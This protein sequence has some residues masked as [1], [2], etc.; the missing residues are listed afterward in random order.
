VQKENDSFM[1]MCSVLNVLTGIIIKYVGLKNLTSMKIAKKIE[2]MVFSFKLIMLG[3][4]M[5]CHA[6]EK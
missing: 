3:D 2:V 5:E 1:C 4:L 6:K